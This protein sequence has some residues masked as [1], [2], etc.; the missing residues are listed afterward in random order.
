[1]EISKEL[2]SL[3]LPELL[4]SHF[5]ISEFKPENKVIHIHFVEKKE[6]PKEVKDQE[7]IGHGFYPEIT[8]RDFPLRGKSVFLHIKR[9]RWKDKSTEQ[10]VKRDWELVAKGS[11]MTVEFAAFLK[12]I[13]IY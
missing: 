7:L 9:R 3:L 1:M 5:D 2:L 12:A 10:I 4:I 11:R 13:S 6:V 8:I